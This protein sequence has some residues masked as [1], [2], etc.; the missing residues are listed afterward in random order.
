MTSEIAEK[1]VHRFR[2]LRFFERLTM[3]LLV[4]V[5]AWAFCAC[6]GMFV[7]GPTAADEYKLFKLTFATGIAGAVFSIYA[8]W[9]ASDDLQVWLYRVVTTATVGAGVGL[10]GGGAIGAGM[11]F[12]AGLGQYEWLFYTVGAVSGISVLTP[13]VWRWMRWRFREAG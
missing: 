6:V 3:S 5:L 8:F 4:G 7:F 12:L 11:A 1:T 2:K 13:L 9:R 10:F